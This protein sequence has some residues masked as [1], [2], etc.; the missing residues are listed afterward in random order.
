MA[1]KQ[2]LTQEIKLAQRL[3]PLQ[4]QLVPLLEMN[5]Q[6][7][8]ERI[9]NELEENPAL[10][11]TTE[12]TAEIN[13]TEDGEE[14][15][16]SAEDLQQADYG[17]DDE[18]PMYSARNRSADDEVFNPG[19][20]A[21]AEETITDYLMDQVRENDLSELQELIAE[22]IVGNLDDNGY[23]TRSPSA[24]ADDI[25]F[26]SGVEVETDQVQEV[27][28]IV[29]RLDPP[30]IA[31]QNLKECLALQLERLPSRPIVEIARLIIGS[32][33]DEFGKKH[34]DR[35]CSVLGIGRDRLK[36]A[37][38]LIATLNP[39]PG[40]AFTGS[41]SEIHSQQITPDFVVDDTDGILSLTLTNRIPELVISKSYLQTGE[42]YAKEKPKS[43]PERE[44][45]DDIKGKID[46]AS[47][48]IKVLRMRQETLFRTMESIMNRQRDFF[49]TGDPSQL[50]PMILK[51]VAG[52]IGSDV[53][54]V[55]RATQNKYV[56]SPWG[57]FS[58]KYFFSEGLSVDDG[59]DVSAY[60]IQQRIQE[61]INNEDKNKP[62]S[63][64][65]LCDMLNAEGYNIARRTVA[66]YRDRLGIP[67]ARLRKEL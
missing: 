36:D 39:K 21:V 48:F 55:S 46:K 1:A 50:K 11:T 64:D 61:A 5:G 57:I 31:A 20:L 35:I 63:D 45:A 9:A 66:K 34:Y 52:D 30:G 16:E 4:L 53:S 33:F 62:L 15:T 26:G 6:E 32:Y 67:V 65:K 41:Q 10:E 14:F 7:L 59:D 38:T 49:L 58:L 25:T 47:T 56:S 37:I 22:Y 18:I 60:Q 13:K 40:S 54:V 17:D 43:G 42:L 29:H 2:Q 51:D 8:E 12:E 23:L 44:Q 28:H 24:I 3:L 19:S 27:L